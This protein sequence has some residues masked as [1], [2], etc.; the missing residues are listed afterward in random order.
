VTGCE[1]TCANGTEFC[2]LGV[3]VVS[4]LWATVALEPA[5]S[6][7]SR[8]IVLWGRSVT[9]LL[10]VMTSDEKLDNGADQKEKAVLLLVGVT[11]ER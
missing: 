3:G 1:T 5:V 11:C 10:L 8:I 7:A 6:A 9:L 2:I 4:C